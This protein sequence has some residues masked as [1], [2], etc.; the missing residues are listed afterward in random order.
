ME[1]S[2]SQRLQG[3]REGQIIKRYSLRK[4]PAGIEKRA[5]N[6]PRCRIKDCVSEEI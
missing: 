1:R 4:V 2:Q 6:R 3:T 5:E